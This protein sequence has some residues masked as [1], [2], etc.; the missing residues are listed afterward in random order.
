MCGVH[1]DLIAQALLGGCGRGAQPRGGAASSARAVIR[2]ASSAR[3]SAGAR[4]SGTNAFNANRTASLRRW[5]LP[6]ACPV[7]RWPQLTDEDLL[8]ARPGHLLS[9]ERQ[10]FE[11]LLPGANTAI[12]DLRYTRGLC[13]DFGLQA[14]EKDQRL[15][16]VHD[17][18]PHLERRGCSRSFLIASPGFDSR[19]SL[20]F[21]TGGE[22]AKP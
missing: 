9:V 13:V 2:G 10:H 12:R 4:S 20:D 1:A 6:G 11:Q 22:T 21:D 18:L 16:E 15:C 19:A 17:L 14:A 7:F 3:T 8:V 5:W